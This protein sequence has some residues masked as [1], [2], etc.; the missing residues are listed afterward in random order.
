MQ[1]RKLFILM[2]L[3]MVVAATIVYADETTNFTEKQ[4]LNMTFDQN[5]NTTMMGTPVGTPMTVAFDGTQPVNVSGIEIG[6]IEITFPAVQTVDFD[7]TQPVSGTFYQVTQPISGA[8]T[9]SGTST[10]TQAGTVNVASASTLEVSIDDHIPIRAEIRNIVDVDQTAR[11]LELVRPSTTT[12]ATQIGLAN[13][14][15][16]WIL[17][18]IDATNSVFLDTASP[19]SASDFEL[20]A[21]QS[22]L[23]KTGTQIFYIFSTDWVEVQIMGEY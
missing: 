5:T 7:G 13:V 18:N 22:I 8:V 17:M 20:K 21:G 14:P 9:T 11:T 6:S 19:A 12:G 3:C 23:G 15:K 2:I 16:E 10:V 1:F 4:I